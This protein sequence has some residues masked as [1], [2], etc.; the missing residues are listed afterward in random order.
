MASEATPSTESDDSLSAFIV[1]RH[2]KGKLK[3]STLAALE[4]KDLEAVGKELDD[5]ITLVEAKLK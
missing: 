1:D 5:L 2:S 3:F 4:A